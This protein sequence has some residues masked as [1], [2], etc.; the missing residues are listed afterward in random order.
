MQK[1]SL[2]AASLIIM[3][4]VFLSGCA[5]PVAESPKFPAKDIVFII[6]RGVGGGNDLTV[7]ALIPG[8]NKALG[9]NVV[10]E[11][12]PAAKGLAAATEIMNAVPDGHK[13]YFNS[14]TLLLM[15]YGGMPNVKLEKFQPVAQVVEDTGA[16]IVAA[17]S[18]YHTLAE[19]IEAG[20]KKEPKLSVAHNGIGGLWHLAASQFSKAAKIDF[21]YV[22]YTTSGMQMLEALVDGEVDL[23]IISPVE[24]KPLIDSGKVRVLAVL[25]D[26][27]HSVVPN[28]PT[29]KEESV[30]A[31]FPVWRG[32]FTT[33]GVSEATLEVLEKAI[34]SAV[35]TEEFKSFAHNNGLPIKFRGHREFQEFAYEQREV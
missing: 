16:V 27:R 35:E 12:K 2:I 11:N 22:A 15:P 5:S 29:C 14:Q 9:I 28:V 8:M 20:K 6:P 7:R 30:D 21:H 17:N 33:M 26:H 31:S 4:Q 23:C 25:S 13:L 32:V 24:S 19:L 34:R 10:A 18:P 1:K 3:I